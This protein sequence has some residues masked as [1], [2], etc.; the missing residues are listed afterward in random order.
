M[1]TA[2]I[3]LNWNGAD[4]TIACLNSLNKAEGD[5]FVV[6][7]DNDSSDNSIERLQEWNATVSHRFAFHLLQEN[8]NHGFAKGNNVGVQYAMQFNPD[9]YLLLNNDTEVESD[10]LSRLLGFSTAHSEYKA[11][12]PRI[13]YYGD[14]SLVWLCGGDLT[15]GSRE[16]FYHNE[17]ESSVHKVEFIPITFIT[18]CALF[19]H[20]SLLMEDGNLLTNR[21]FF[22]EEDYEF[23]M[24]MKRDGYL[25]A[26]IP[27]SV[28]YHKVGVSRDK[29]G[30]KRNIGKDYAFYLSKLICCRLFYNPVKFGVLVAL[31]APKSSVNFCKSTGSLMKSLKLT[32]RLIKE[33][34]TKNGISRDDFQNYVKW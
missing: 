31:V 11:L 24:R 33:A 1:T 29:I 34:Y 23:S 2:I 7:V 25:M 22:G 12:M 21:F 6:C 13:N 15:F 18:G 14:K 5:F 10:F 32:V 4:D 8:E 30:D 16:R 19:A 20:S 9:Y 28:I 27:N 26:C 3:L 17:S